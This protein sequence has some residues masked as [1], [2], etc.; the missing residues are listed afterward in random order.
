MS[1]W[2]EE[3]SL[4]NLKSIFIGVKLGALPCGF[5]FWAWTWIVFSKTGI[6]VGKE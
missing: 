1:L 6:R 5:L 2:K 4:L 3:Y